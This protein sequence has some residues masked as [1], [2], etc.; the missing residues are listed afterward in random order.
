MSMLPSKS[1]YDH[2]VH[3]AGPS[4]HL[5]FLNNQF[6]AYIIFWLLHRFSNTKEKQY[7]KMTWI[8][9]FSNWFYWI[10][11]SIF[12]SHNPKSQ[13][14][15]MH[16]SFYNANQKQNP[17]AIKYEHLRIKC[18]VYIGFASK[19]SHTQTQTSP[20]HRHRFPPLALKHQHRIQL[21]SHAAKMPMV[22]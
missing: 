5:P 7:T 18:V 9:L 14:Y 12:I 3:E 1:I 19:R 6:I 8:T 21:N 13:S 17:I 15:S 20:V 11:P 22:I 2:H 16:G 10:L 4:T